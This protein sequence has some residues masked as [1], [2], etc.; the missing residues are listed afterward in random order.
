MVV[1]FACAAILGSLATVISVWSIAWVWALL[2]APFGGSLTA[3]LVAIVVFFRGV[4]VPPVSAAKPE[5]SAR[6]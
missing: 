1:I 2:C 4:S 3:L 6:H 5:V